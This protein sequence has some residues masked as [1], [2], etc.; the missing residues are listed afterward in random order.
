MSAAVPHAETILKAL[1]SLC[2][3]FNAHEDREPLRRGLRSGD[4]TW[5]R[6]VGD[7][8]RRQVCCARG[9]GRT[10]QGDAGRPLR[11]R[12]APTK[13]RGNNHR[14]GGRTA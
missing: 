8:V 3:A 11:G 10:L 7:P 2:D 6:S 5:A 9:I 1:G 4:A 12:G 14:C 13:G